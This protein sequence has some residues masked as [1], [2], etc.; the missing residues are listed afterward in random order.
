MLAPGADG[1]GSRQPGRPCRA[2][3]HNPPMSGL[4]APTFTRRRV[5]GLGIAAVGVGYFGRFAVG[6]TFEQHVADVLGLER[7]AADRLLELLRAELGADYDVRAAAFMAATTAPGRWVVP[8]GLRREA[9]QAF[10]GP[11]FGVEQGSVTAL[12]Y[13]GSSSAR[14][15]TGCGVLVRV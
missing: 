9:L 7:P 1:R 5:L 14:P 10:V 8:S 13:G 15:V 12:V 3:S 11:L 6:G 2:V 4:S